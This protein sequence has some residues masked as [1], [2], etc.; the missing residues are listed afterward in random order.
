M[1]IDIWL[2][3]SLSTTFIIHFVII[4]NTIIIVIIIIIIGYLH[5][6]VLSHQLHTPVEYVRHQGDHKHWPAWEHLIHSIIIMKR[7]DMKIKYKI[8]IMY[9]EWWWWYSYIDDDDNDY[10]YD[11]GK[12]YNKI[13]ASS[14]IYR[15]MSIHANIS[16]L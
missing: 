10:C 14:I 9:L 7:W 12:F 13:Y 4:V 6:P 11:D 3:S 5:Y 2:S 15:H 1:Q 8:K 16:N